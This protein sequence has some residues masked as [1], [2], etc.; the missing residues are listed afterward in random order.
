[1]GWNHQPVLFLARTFEVLLNIFR[2]FFFA[3]QNR[4]GQKSSGSRNM[5]GTPTITISTSLHFECVNWRVFMEKIP[6]LDV[7]GRKWRKWMDQRWVRITGWN[8][9]PTKIP[10]IS[11]WNNPL[12]RSP[13]ILTSVPGHPK[14][15]IFHRFSVLDTTQGAR[16]GDAL[17]QWP[18]RT[19]ILVEEL[20]TVNVVNGGFR[21]RFFHICQLVIEPWNP[22][23]SGVFFPENLT[24]FC[25]VGLFEMCFVTKHPWTCRWGAHN[26]ELFFFCVSIEPKWCCLLVFE[27]YLG[28][29]WFQFFFIFTPHLGMISNLTNIFQMGWNH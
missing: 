28:A 19:K 11:R 2:G 21:W 23:F 7:P 29:R 6:Y 10:F 25:P 5:R 8:F 27:N 12:I 4:W 16:F 17:V 22:S 1:M 26:F 3:K 18:G 20:W 24:R 9:T 14:I 13:S 15:R